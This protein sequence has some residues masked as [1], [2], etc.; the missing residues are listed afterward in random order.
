MH[1]GL[2]KVTVIFVPL[3][4][5]DRIG[6]RPLLIASNVGIC[7]AQLLIS[8]SF[9]FGPNNSSGGDTPEPEPEPEPEPDIPPLSKWLAVGGQCAFVASF[10]LGVGPLA[11]V[12][13]SELYPLRLRGAR[14][15]VH[16]RSV[17]LC[18]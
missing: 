8:M 12:L 11:H 13:S 15:S 10:S 6:R 1:A 16:F 2:V 17:S 4:L 3:L 9:L 5:M 18:V 14:P 7:L